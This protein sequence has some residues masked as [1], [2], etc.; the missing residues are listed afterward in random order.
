MSSEASS[1]PSASP[2]VPLPPATAGSSSSSSS[3]AD[4]AWRFVMDYS[5]CRVAKQLRLLGYD[6]VC[7]PSIRKE[8]ILYLCAAEGRVVVTGSRH[9]VPC[10]ER[11]KR[12]AEEEGGPHG[13]RGAAPAATKRPPPRRKAV[14]YNSDGESEYSSSDDECTP[15]PRGITYIVVKS[16]DVH[17]VNMRAIV[18][19]LQLKWD[20]TKVFSRCVT[21]NLLIQRVE[22]GVAESRVHPT[23]FRVYMN[24]YQCPGCLK[25]YWGVDNGV[26]VNYK[27]L[28]TI[29][30]LKSFCHG[31]GG[32][33]AMK[34]GVGEGMQRHVMAYPR[35]VKTC[36]FSFLGR[37][38]LERMVEALPMFAEL[39]KIVLSGSSTKFVHSKKLQSRVSAESSDDDN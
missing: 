14:A 1:G 13:G 7:S 36:I 33:I 11:L 27:A 28:R 22:K 17:H 6:V 24:F 25:V 8:Q 35:A 39:V 2:A 20:L 19:A 15:H 4:D 18:Q 26:I 23:V 38:D 31:V 9:L 3:K 34:E 16:T 37:E 29:D 10:L 30:Y 21:C 5:L 32:V 12:L